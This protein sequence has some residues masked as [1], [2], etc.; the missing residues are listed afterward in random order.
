MSRKFQSFYIGIS[1]CTLSLYI[2][3]YG[4]SFWAWLLVSGDA[5]HTRASSYQ[6]PH[7]AKD[8]NHTEKI[9]RANFNEFFFL[10]NIQLCLL[11]NIQQVYLKGKKCI[12]PCNCQF[13][14]DAKEKQ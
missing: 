5:A 1:L 14:T 7:V 6:I 11:E 2:Y 3:I 10:E 12:E 13:S 8:F 4:H 9:L